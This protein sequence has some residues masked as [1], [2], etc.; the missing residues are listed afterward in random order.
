MKKKLI[1]SV[2]LSAFLLTGVASPAM[3][4]QQ[5]KVTLPNFSVTL[6]DY[7][8]ESKYNTYPLIVYKDITYFPMTYHYGSFLGLSTNWANNTLT[9]EKAIPTKH[10]VRWYKQENANKNSYTAT[11]AASKI[12]VNGKTIQNSKEKYPLLL[13]R[14]V[15]YFPLT[16][17][18]AVDEFGWDYSFDSKNG[19]E[20]TSRIMGSSDQYFTKGDIIVG[21]P[22]NSY[23]EKFTFTYR[24]GIDKER[25]FSLESQL[26]D[27]MYFFNHQAD[28][29][30]Y[31]TFAE[32]PKAYIEGN[33]LILPSV[34][35]NDVTAEKE[36][37]I[38]KIDFV[39]GELISKDPAPLLPVKNK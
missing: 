12:V 37:L 13:F 38:L 34:R 18:F 24:D 3:A 29:N 15:T 8:M 21:C 5:V 20:I 11:V 35:Q 9:V 25:E 7:T 6:N 30:G 31:V 36:N 14:D 26:L 32:E 10:F 23:N 39:K 16:W 27:G 33:I 19:L 17:R 4:A 22:F 1:A 28:E 2:A